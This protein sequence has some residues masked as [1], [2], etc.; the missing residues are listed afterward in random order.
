MWTVNTRVFFNYITV[1]DSIQTGWDDHR[2]GFSMQGRIVPLCG[3]GQHLSCH[4]IAVF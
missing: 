2:A 3:P 1:T 4:F